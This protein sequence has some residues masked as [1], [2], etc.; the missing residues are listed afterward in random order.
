MSWI[1][2]AGVASA[3]LMAATVWAAAQMAPGHPGMHGAA[4]PQA[5][6]P[7]AAQPYAGLQDRQIKGLSEQQIADLRA[8][9][10]MML[11]LPAELNGYPGPAH[12]LE[13][14]DQIGLSAETRG[15]IQQ[16]FDAM[17]VEAVPLGRRLIEQEADLDRQFA[18]HT[19]TA[20]GLKQSIAALGETQTELRNTH[21]K[22]HLL[23]AP[24]LTPA[25]LEQYAELRGYRGGL[26]MHQHG[27]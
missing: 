6:Q 10:G 1:W 27:R 17:K 16:M 14:A 13:L 4:G 12:L 9:R 24:L 22:Y 11:A 8:G 21:L 2:K 26:A 19:I 3:A 15:R 23:T 5:V 18:N 20:E 7:S 25:Q